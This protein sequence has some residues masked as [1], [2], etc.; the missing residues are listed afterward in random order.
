MSDS[1]DPKNF[2]EI[3]SHI[4]GCEKYRKYYV[5]SHEKRRKRRKLKKI[6]RILE[7]DILPPSQNHVYKVPPPSPIQSP[8]DPIDSE[9]Y[10]F[11]HDLNPITIKEDPEPDFG[12]SGQFTIKNESDIGENSMKKKYES[13]W[14]EFCKLRSDYF[15]IHSRNMELINQNSKLKNEI[16]SMRNKTKITIS[17]S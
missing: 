13:L 7:K 9:S 12:T 2:T 5:K 16:I 8:E 11:E 14:T 10:G 15:N 3:K 4:K 6:Q 1:V 17:N